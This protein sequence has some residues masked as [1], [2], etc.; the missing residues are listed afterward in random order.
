MNVLILGGAGM[1]G[2]YVA[3]ELAPAHNL[4]IT[5]I[6]PPEEDLPGEFLLLDAADLDGVVAAAEGM[7][8]ILNLSVLRRHRQTA[9]DVSTRGCYNMM[10]AASF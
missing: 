5:D 3:R 6:N 7:D 10:Q 9:W 8:A 1:L 2:P 4:R